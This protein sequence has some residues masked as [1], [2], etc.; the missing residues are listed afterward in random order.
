MNILDVIGVAEG[1]DVTLRRVRSG[2]TGPL[3]QTCTG[4]YQRWMFV[5]GREYGPD[6]ILGWLESGNIRHP[7]AYV[8]EKLLASGEWEL[9]R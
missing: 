3:E 6:L 1:Q 2:L 4:V 8:L 7:I 5:D 9:Q